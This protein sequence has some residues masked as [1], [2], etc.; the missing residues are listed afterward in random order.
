MAVNMKTGNKYFVDVSG[1]TV[2][3]VLGKVSEDGGMG[4]FFDLVRTPEQNLGKNVKLN[5]DDVASDVEG[6]FILCFSVEF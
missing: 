3:K 1:G 4:G 2:T 5:S 6:V